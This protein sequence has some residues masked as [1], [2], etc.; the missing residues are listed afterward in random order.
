VSLKSLSAGVSMNNH[1]FKSVVTAGLLA[2]SMAAPA[3]DIDLFVNQPPVADG[4]QP[5]VLIILDNTANWST[6]FENEKAALKSVFDEL[7]V[8]K[9]RVGLMMFSESGGSNGNPGGAYVRAAL[10]LMDETNKPAYS[11]LVNSLSNTS[12]DT[13]QGSARALGLS[14]AEAYRYY[15]AQQA[16]AGHNKVKR[17]FPGNVITPASVYAGSNSVYQLAG[18]AFS[19]SASTVYTNPVENG[20]QKNFII[21]IG[22]TPPSGSPS[23]DNTSDN[24]TARVLLSDAAGGGAAG[25][26][27]VEEIPISPTGFSDNIANE[28]ARFMKN[29]PLRIKTF[30]VDVSQGTA[31]NA[32]AN[33]ALLKSMATESDGEY[34]LVNSGEGGKQIADALKAIFSEIQSVNSAFASVSLPV[35]VNTQGTFL[36]QVY[37]G[38]FR[39]DDESGPRWAGNLKHYKLGYDS[40]NVLALLDADDKSAISSSGT[41]FISECARSFWTPTLTDNYWVNKPQGGCLAVLNSD[42]SN[43]PDGNIVEKGAQAFK[44][45]S[46]TARSVLTCNSGCTGLTAFNNTSVTQTDLGATD[47]T[48]RDALINWARGLNLDGELGKATTVM[49]PSVHGD[50]VHS[51]PVAINYGTDAAPEVVV[52]YGANDGMLH[53]V[54]G[55]RD[56][57]L[58]IG[59]QGPGMELW[60][61]MAPEF[62]PHIKRIRTNTPLVSYFGSDT[63]EPKPYGFDGPTAAYKDADQATVYAAMRRGGRAL[64]AFDVTAPATP[65]LKWKHDATSLP[66]LGQTWSAP[67]ILTAT[68]YASPM[69]IMGGGYDTCE[70]A[71]PHACTTST[72]G[73]RI[74]VMDADDGTLM[75]TLNTDRAVVADVVVVP[76]RAT[77]LAKHAYAVDLG[78]NVYRI[79][80]G[81]AAPADWSI[82]KIASL[83]GAGTDARKFMFA[84]DVVEDY[85]VY[86]LLLGSG[87]R[88]KPLLG[89]TAAASVDN[90]FFM[91]KD[92][93]AVTPVLDDCGGSSVICLNSLY[94]ILGN[95]SPTL[96]DVE[97]KK[98]WYL[99]L[100]PTE[101][102]VTSAITIF[103]TVTFSTHEPAPLNTDPNVCTSTLGTARVYN[104]AYATAVSHN[105]TADRFETVAGGGLS[106]SPVAGMVT[107]DNGETVPFCIGCNPESALQGDPAD[108]PPPAIQPKSRVYWNIQQ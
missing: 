42:A 83:G 62:Y 60:S 1:Y 70:D 84:P 68:G 93:P 100:S 37:I 77:G 31:G 48:E 7:P 71:D 43:S 3:E 12:P 67:K 18:N 29:S 45:R 53:A 105:G 17:D 33:S 66:N 41:G 65:A 63:G 47:T 69:L 35:S 101:Q 19:S 104:V 79:N 78:G 55:N 108:P 2:L 5:N 85:G 64:Y 58:S 22:N 88:E 26:A 95:S 98:G 34:F 86:I 20:C 14:M 38:M 80:I 16:F 81:T 75:R 13:D 27:A 51:R 21:Y 87:D 4:T 52:F 74:Y 11:S 6:A 39:P 40:S 102:V 23:K 99:A 49:R 106:P 30:T 24:D 82:T 61:F 59:T 76:D 72:T 15:A 90:Y 36:N 97:A 46:T 50:V 103:G 32:L 89:Y 94:P 8:G 54:N 92:D 107:L 96:A 9:F 91:L 10:R 57:G 73:N 25:A 56:G 28:W 44:L